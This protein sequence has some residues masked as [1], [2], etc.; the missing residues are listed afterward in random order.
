MLGSCKKDKEVEIVYSNCPYGK[1]FTPMSDSNV[2]CDGLIPLS[3]I[4]FWI[5]ADSVWEDG[6]LKSTTYDTLKVISAEI[7][8]NDIWWKLSDGYCLSQS[9]DTVYKLN[10]NGFVDAGSVVC[11][12]KTVLFFPVSTDTVQNW[13]EVTSDY[14]E[15]GI[16]YLNGD[17]LIT[18]AGN[19]SGCLVFV[20]IGYSTYTRILEPGIGVVKTIEINDFNMSIKSRTL[21]SYKVL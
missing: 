5:Y 1:N 19:F 10:F 2:K 11:P 7:S 8:D 14:I 16:A 17:I 4:N 12:E 3:L 13:H 18:A 20:R 6:I 9:N 21:V 15:N